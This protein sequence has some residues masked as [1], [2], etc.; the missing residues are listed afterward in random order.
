MTYAKSATET[1]LRRNTSPTESV[2]MRLSD[3]LTSALQ[4]ASSTVIQAPT[5]AGKTYTVSTTQWR[6]RPDVTG[7]KPVVVLEPTTDARDEAAEDNRQSGATSTVLRGRQE[8]CDLAGGNHD[9]QIVAPDGRPPSEWFDHLCDKRGFP[10]SVAHTKFKQEFGG[11]LPCQPCALSGQWEDVPQDDDGQPS[12]DIILATHQFAR[13]PGLVENC[14]VIF[15]E[16]PDFTLD[17]GK[18]KLVEAVGNYLSY[19]D[20]PISTWEGLIHEYA[21]AEDTR[22]LLG[23]LRRPDIGWFHQQNHSHLLVPGIVRAIVA[24]EQHMKDRWRGEVGYPVPDLR[25]NSDS[26][27]GTI[28]IRI[29]IDDQYRIQ[30][31]QAIPD[32]SQA[33]CVVG[34]DAHPSLPKWEANTALELDRSQ[35]LTS[36]ER[37]QW[38]RYERNLQIVQVGQNTNSWTTGGTNQPKVKT[39]VAELRHRFD[40]DFA[41]GITAKRAKP[42]VR[43][44]MEEAGVSSPELLHFGNEKSVNSLSGEEVGL[45]AGCISPSDDDVINWLTLLNKQARPA[46]EER[47]DCYRQEFVGQ[48]DDVAADLVK[49]VREHRVLQAIGRYARQPGESDDEA[50]VYVMTD[51]IPERYVDRQVSDPTPFGNKQQ[52]VLSTLAEA[53]EPLSVNDLSERVD[54]STKHIY[55]TIDACQEAAWYERRKNAGA[56]NANL[57][58]AERAPL[59]LAEV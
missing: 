53:D 35:V 32:F 5:S 19:I 42:E 49:S 37:Q 23:E 26:S 3:A 38:R 40:S 57:H 44:A 9:N 51:A 28:Q 10:A 4:E 58:S 33:R 18:S 14:N 15:D 48:D 47:D 39:L 50:T 13:V 2:Q 25:Y 52:E 12:S 43:G 21:H 8:Q 29:V 22:D 27:Q 55:D 24:A 30:I 31:I 11:K 1:H 59:G 20:A 34:L 45:V 46:R 56:Y 41:S 36:E 16:Q 54:A 7:G 17:I 6:E